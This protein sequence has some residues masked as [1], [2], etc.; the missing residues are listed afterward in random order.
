[1]AAEQRGPEYHRKN[2]EQYAAVMAGARIGDMRD[3][4]SSAAV[5]ELEGANFSTVSLPGIRLKNGQLAG[6]VFSQ[7]VM[8]GAVLDGAAAD[9]GS[10]AGTDL[11]DASCRQTRFIHADLR[12]AVFRNADC[13][14][15]DFRKA[16][17]NGADFTGADLTGVSF[18]GAE[19]RG[20]MFAGAVL[21]G[22]RFEGA[23]L[24]KADLKKCSAKGAGFHAAILHE[25]SASGADLAGAD[26]SESVLAKA[27]L[28]SANLT[29]V[30]ASL[31][32]ASSVNFYAATLSHAVFRGADLKSGMFWKANLA[33]ADLTWADI[34]DAEFS[35]AN[36]LGADLSEAYLDGAKIRLA[37]IR[38]AKFRLV[39]VDGRTVLTECMVDDNTDFTGVGLGGVRIEPKLESKL[40]RNVRKV[41][42]D[43][44]TDKR[45]LIQWFE[46]FSGRIPEM[47]PPKERTPYPAENP[48]VA[49][50]MRQRG[51]RHIERS[52]Y[53][54][55]EFRK[56]PGTAL[57]KGFCQIL[58]TICVNIPV[59]L[60][61]KI[62]DYGS[63]TFPI[64]I[65][66]ILLNLFFTIIYMG[67]IPAVSS[68]G[69]GDPIV[70]LGTADPVLGFLRT[71]SIIFIVSEISTWGLDAFAMFC[72]LV[73]VILGYFILAALV[74]RFAVMFQTRSQ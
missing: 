33:N 61:W 40:M 36:L 49:M 46:K 39:S 60:F 59:R 29:K 4:N 8:T 34:K 72:V 30:N 16:N 20:V 68:I 41:W 38:G 19:L 51:R 55:R 45:K 71:T 74:T 65:S 5:A 35:E 64:V 18:E 2:A 66:F 42:W 47:E 37:D 9:D 26:L 50:R 31:A 13:T 56:N 10:F 32:A 3:W 17:L 52:A 44:W 15:A 1:M 6:A 70:F 73:H 21:D 7:A 25:A 22:A 28:S 63:R 67:L 58:E 48:S 27:D 23:D 11:T 57:L 24:T 54:K 43:E 53:W 14:G 12:S 69:G 62:S